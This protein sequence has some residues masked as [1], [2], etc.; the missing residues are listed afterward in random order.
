MN[1]ENFSTSGLNEHQMKQIQADVQH[2]RAVQEGRPLSATIMGTTG[3]GKSS[4][5]NA[6]FGTDLATG[7]VRPVTKVPEPVSVVGISGHSMIFWDMPGIGESGSADTRYLKMYQKKLIESDIVIWAI[8]ADNRSTTYDQLCLGKML[9]AVAPSQQLSLMSKLTF[10]LTKADILTPPPWVFDMHGETGSFAPSGR[11]AARLE[12]KSAYYE[13]VFLEPWHDLLTSSTYNH[14]Q[15]DV[16]DS[17]LSFDE[18]T[19]RY[20]G[21]F[22]QTVC[23]K[24]SARYPAHAEIFSRLRDNHRVLPCSALFRFNLLP[25]MVTVV[26]KLGPGA[27]F[28]FQRLLDDID[29]VTDVPVDAVRGYGNFVIWDAKRGRKAF[30]LQNLSLKAAR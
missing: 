30:D 17:R 14:A 3:V 8:H 9:N 24:Y 19:V 27:V 29:R 5:F 1:I 26:N 18:Y 6:L 4:L 22:T 10:V 21:H 12:E 23:D 11:L 25:L 2:E 16:A 7:D 15:F 28:R 13:S 20:H